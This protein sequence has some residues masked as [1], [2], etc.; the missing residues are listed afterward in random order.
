MSTIRAQSRQTVKQS[1]YVLNSIR[2]YGTDPDQS[3]VENGNI[4]HQE[5]QFS[6]TQNVATVRFQ[7]GN[8][9]SSRIVQIFLFICI[10]FVHMERIS[11][12]LRL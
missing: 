4:T 7:C 9:Y 3:A 1:L 8:L 6:N 2:Q 10:E 5:V 12:T 11:Q